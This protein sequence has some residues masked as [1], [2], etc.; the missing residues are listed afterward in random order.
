VLYIQEATPPTPFAPLTL[1]LTS[2]VRSFNFFEVIFGFGVDISDNVGIMS[3]NDA[4][5]DIHPQG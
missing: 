3:I 5:F 1:L 2:D 4:P